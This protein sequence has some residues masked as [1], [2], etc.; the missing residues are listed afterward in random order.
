VD[1]KVEKFEAVRAY[2]LEYVAGLLWLLSLVLLAGADRSET[3]VRVVQHTFGAQQTTFAGQV[4]IV[5]AAVVFGVVV[6]YCAAAVFRPV[7][8]L[9]ADRLL[10]ADRAWERWRKRNRASLFGPRVVAILRETLDLPELSQVGR[11]PKLTFLQV[12]EPSLLRFIERDRDELWFRVAAALPTALLAGVVLTRISTERYAVLIG[13]AL[14]AAMFLI[15]VR[16]ANR[17]LAAWDE[18]IDTAIILVQQRRGLVLAATEKGLSAAVT[19]D[20]S[21]LPPA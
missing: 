13:I 9:I 1:A 18:A 5:S 12:F 7:A 15:A 4:L 6:P 21:E 20:I 14:A 19:A 11:S 10:R 17:D 8:L 3:V 2:L 16:Q